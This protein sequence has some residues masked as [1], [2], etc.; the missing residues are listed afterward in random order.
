MRVLFARMPG[1]TRYRYHA[2]LPYV[3]GLPRSTDASDKALKEN[4]VL[5]MNKGNMFIGDAAPRL[6]DVDRRRSCFGTIEYMQAALRDSFAA[7][8]RDSFDLVVFAMANMIRPG[9]N[10]EA[11]VELVERLETKFIVLGAGMQGELPH[12]LGALSPSTRRLLEVFNERAAV[13]GVRGEITKAWLDAV[14][15][16]RAM[17]L[18]CPSLY[19]YPRNVLSTRPVADSAE[20]VYATAG[21]LEKKSPRAAALVEF[22]RG[23]RAEY[24]F[25]E[26]IFHK[27]S[28]FTIPPLFYNDATGECDAALAREM[29]EPV[30]GVPLPFRRYWYFQDPEAWRQLYS[31]CTAYIGDRFHGGVG[32]MQ[33]GTTALVVYKDLR[34]RE[35]TRFFAIPHVHVD[36]IARTPRA[37]V[38]ARHLSAEAMAAFHETYARRVRDF[39]GVMRRNGIKLSYSDAVRAAVEAGA[40]DGA[41]EP[42]A[43]VA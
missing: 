13:F 4:Y 10:H 26:E 32:A 14:G 9:Q 19:V 8:L 35:L 28:G 36:E 43:A 5:T 37:E 2:G 12:D 24:I 27:A 42:A 20:A 15:L 39:I 38:I 3:S 7:T 33:A 16:D 31:H 18:G 34:V 17:A 30:H 25:Q 40:A 41:R 22:F 29:L 1:D 21:Y 23:S 11:L 6:F